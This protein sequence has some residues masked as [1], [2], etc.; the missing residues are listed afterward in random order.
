MSPDRSY[1]LARELIDIDGDYA[2]HVRTTGGWQQPGDPYHR[3]LP[4]LDVLLAARRV[5][6]ARPTGQVWSPNPE[7]LHVRSGDGRAELRFVTRAFAETGFCRT[8]GCARLLDDAGL[9]ARCATASR[10]SQPVGA[11]AA[12]VW[13]VLG[14]GDSAVVPVT[15]NDLTTTDLVNLA[16]TCHTLDQAFADRS[17]LPPTARQLLDRLVPVLEDLDEGRSRALDVEEVL[18]RAEL[19]TL[20]GAGLALYRL[21]RPHEDLD[22]LL[23]R[24]MVLLL[25]HLDYE[26]TP[27]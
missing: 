5:L 8:A 6:R 24:P 26:D 23:T 13:R 10:A 9:C 2:V 20:A 25:A 11:A 16:R 7:T 4:G 3:E 18:S 27:D 12:P 1:A 15:W 22:D 21:Y 14:W 19:L 17:V